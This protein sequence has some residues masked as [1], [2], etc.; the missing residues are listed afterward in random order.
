MDRPDQRRN[1]RGLGLTYSKFI[2][3]LKKA[4][5]DMDRKVLSDMAIHDPAA[6]AAIVDKVKAQL[7]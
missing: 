7:A 4:S 2:A 6:F 1:S 5:I 3:G